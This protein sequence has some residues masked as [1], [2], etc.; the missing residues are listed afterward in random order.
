MIIKRFVIS[1]KDLNTFSTSD[2]FKNLHNFSDFENFTN[3]W[4]IHEL[5]KT[6][7]N[8]RKLLSLVNAINNVDT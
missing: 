4:L 1:H 3:I 8:E 6:A 7:L 5:N 2:F